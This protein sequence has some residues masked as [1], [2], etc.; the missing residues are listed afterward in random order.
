MNQSA[1]ILEIISSIHW[2][3]T[4]I[5]TAEGSS[6]PPHS[7]FLC[8]SKRKGYNRRNDWLRPLSYVFRSLREVYEVYEAAIPTLLLGGYPRRKH[9]Q[10]SI[11]PSSDELTLSRPLLELEHELGKRFFR[12]AKKG[13]ILTEARRLLQPRAKKSFLSWAER[14]KK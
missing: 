7:S 4:L 14:K 13:L 9:N 12:A 5:P 3:L 8:F 10:S 6:Y 1:S 2:L 11:I